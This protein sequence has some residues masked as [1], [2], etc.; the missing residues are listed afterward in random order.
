VTE[1]CAWN[2]QIPIVIMKDFL[3]RKTTEAK[4]GDASGP[5]DRR[6]PSAA[7]RLRNRSVSDGVGSS[8]SLTQQ[9]NGPL[10]PTILS[11]LDEEEITTCSSSVD[12]LERGS[13]GTPPKKLWE[14]Q[15]GMFL[16]QRNRSVENLA[17]SQT[18]DPTTNR[19]PSSQSSARASALPV[20]PS[21]NHPLH[22]PG[23]GDSSVRGGKLFASVFRASDSALTKGG[24]KNASTDELDGTMR[25]GSE[26]SFHASPRSSPHNRRHPSNSSLSTPTSVASGS[27]TNHVLFSK[28]SLHRAT[29]SGS[30]SFL[31]PKISAREDFYEE[32]LPDFA[33]DAL[34]P[35]PPFP[36]PRKSLATTRNAASTPPHRSSEKTPLAQKTNPG[37]SFSSEMKLAFTQIRHSTGEDA[38]S[39]FLGDDPSLSNA[40]NALFTQ[41][42]IGTAA[43]SNTN[44]TGL[45]M[46]SLLEPV[47]ERGTIISSSKRCLKPLLGVETWET[48]R[49]YLI[50]PAV[51]SACPVAAIQC[52]FGNS[53]ATRRSADASS[54]GPVFGMIHLGECL[55]SYVTGASTA[56]TT[57]EWTSA[58]LVLRQN[59]LLEYD[60]EANVET[61][62]PRGF[63]HLENAETQLHEHFLDALEL[64]F[65]GSPCAKADV[66]R[67]MIR[68]RK[69]GKHKSLDDSVH[70][71]PEIR[72]A[73][74]TCLN[75]A[76]SL[77]RISDLYDYDEANLL[78]KGQYSEVRAARRRSAA[79]SDEMIYDC[80]I[81]IFGKDKFWR[82]VVKG[83]ERADTI[84]RE[85]SVQS[86]LLAR[87][88][89]NGS[90]LQIRGFFETSKQVV[91]ELELLEGTDLFKY[92]SSKT[93]L[94]EPEAAMIISDVL[95]CL[96]D[97]SKHG[98][99]HRDVKPANILMCRTVPSSPESG[100]RR[101]ARVKVGD[102]GM[103]TFV[104]VDGQVRGRCGTPG[105]V[106][107]EIFTAGVFGGYG[108]KVDVFSAGVTLY[109]MLC[110][111]E[112]FYGET[113]EQLKEA[114]KVALV[115]FPTEDWSNISAAA[116]DLVRQMMQPD[117]AKRLDAQ[118]TLEHPWILK[119]VPSVKEG[120][121]TGSVGL[122]S[123]RRDDA[124]LIS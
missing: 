45:D 96:D 122:P 7:R 51:L 48:G 64:R 85:T 84:V 112:P 109:V 43:H 72:V 82:M 5:V 107:P 56:H 80:A 102:F 61:D 32:H 86:T 49:R 105:Y 16:R 20:S 81:K 2:E 67:L 71:H 87:C 40:Q 108:N 83:R 74:Q 37:R 8:S 110:G 19:T 79:S 6:L 116:K 46:G 68:I 1:S 69:T 14:R 124:C 97:M 52:L 18:I 34:P 76:S 29:S 28:A 60:V 13:P 113:D 101:T 118:Q 50:A 92:V 75:R 63:A 73:W 55:L 103:A 117:P 41:K 9:S 88:S 100:E 11:V 104:G 120:A 99:A 57:K 106:A 70:L 91:L 10:D 31:L 3:H 115:E 62:V 21:S 65:F 121:E 12:L 42:R 33:G 114:N 26:K 95:R 36:A 23:G 53:C 78:G 17:F 38:T 39:V 44:L 59:Y 30:T 90:F 77:L 54:H 27:P 94:K 58:Q 24:R 89:S 66:R 25:R 22:L 15:Y 47:Q 93:V 98:L 35:G 111:Y 4:D 123:W 119:H